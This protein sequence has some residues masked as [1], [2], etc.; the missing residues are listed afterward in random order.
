[1][2]ALCNPLKGIQRAF[3]PSF[4]TKNQEVS[5]AWGTGLRLNQTLRLL[6]FRV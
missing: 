3:I 4:P 5:G 2:R 1:M 6:G